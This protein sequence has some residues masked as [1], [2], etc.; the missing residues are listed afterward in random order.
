[1][2]EGGDVKLIE[3]F[4]ELWKLALVLCGTF[5][6]WIF[7]K[8]IKEMLPKLNRVKMPGTEFDLEGGKEK[9]IEAPSQTAP[10]NLEKPKEDEESNSIIE[11]QDNEEPISLLSFWF[12]LRDRN[13]D[14]ANEIEKKLL[15]AETD[16][17]EKERLSITCLSYRYQITKDKPALATLQEYSESEDERLVKL[18]SYTLARLGYCYRAAEQYDKAIPAF[19]QAADSAA[20]EDE[21][22][23]SIVQ[24]AQCQIKSG[25]SDEAL[26]LLSK[27]LGETL[28]EENRA[29]LFK[30]IASTEKEL[31]DKVMEAVALEKVTEYEP[32]DF[33]AAFAAAYAQSNVNM[34]YISFK[35][36]LREIHLNLDSSMGTNNLGVQLA[37]LEMPMQSVKY[38][39]LAETKGNTLSA[40]NLAS[41]LI[42]KGFHTDAR[43]LLIKAQSADDVHPNVNRALAAIN[44]QKTQET[45]Q[46]KK[47]EELAE[48]HK[49]F[50]RRFAEAYYIPKQPSP[51]FMGNWL[52]RGGEEIK[53]TEEQATISMEWGSGPKRT[54]ITGKQ[55]NGGAKVTIYRTESSP[56]SP[57]TDTPRYDAGTS[58]LA[59]L[60]PDASEM[61][62]T[63]F[64][65]DK[66]F[67]LVLS[68]A[69]AD[70][71]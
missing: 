55:K 30:E 11:A 71:D 48:Q 5:L 8:Q 68:K 43:E 60:S 7:R 40:A 10:G 16:G 49:R 21:R 62:I 64:G 50:L 22:I 57:T 54:K 42:S 23:P 38:Y 69:K 67:S 45:E 26:Q 4:V 63:A 6:I 17:L 33:N 34:S 3:A 32:E 14:K 47:C 18:K 61:H 37:E 36:Y 70:T 39:R 9:D 65:K 59:Y 58:G 31:G 2:Q 1:M 28:S 27:E 12:T 19:K 29:T 24:I 15:E 53:I 46:W 44:D 52:L 25:L 35:N 51:R 41:L 66:P 56:F 20:T 13:F